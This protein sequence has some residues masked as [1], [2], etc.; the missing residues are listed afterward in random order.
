MLSSGHSQADGRGDISLD[1]GA[2]S[3]RV[4]LSFQTRSLNEQVRVLLHSEL[5]AARAK[6]RGIQNSVLRTDIYIFFYQTFWFILC[7]KHCYENIIF[8]PIKFGWFFWFKHV[9]S[10]LVLNAKLVNKCSSRLDDYL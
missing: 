2:E 1:H 6:W 5:S 10:S 8:L 3:V 7:F 9:V 4:G